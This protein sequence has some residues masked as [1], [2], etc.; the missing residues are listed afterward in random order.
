MAC[1]SY[2][3]ETTL[4][5]DD[6]G[7]GRSV[8]IYWDFENLHAG[9]V[10]GKYGEGTYAK[11]DNRFKPQEP[12]VDVQALVELG[13]SF[14]PVAINRA[15]CNWQF[16]GRYRDAL[17]QSAVELIQLFPP[18]ASAKNG[19]DIK[20][21]LDATEDISRFDHI[22]TVIIIGGDSDFMPVAQK[23]KAAGRTLIGIGNRK[24]TNKH[25]AKSCHEFRYYDS[26]VEPISTEDAKPVIAEDAPPPPQNLAA[27]ILRRAIRLLAESKGDAWVHKA[28]VWPMIKRLDPTFD[29]KDHGYTSFGEMLKALD[30]VVEVKKGD[31]DH[32][33]RLR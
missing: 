15:Y 13:S 14:G 7:N 5:Y 8:A 1:D 23:I 16:F 12:L 11:Q 3:G 25:W 33:L 28:N 18:G 17:L 31:K 24:N 4:D 10:E 32:L 2:T 19:A 9:L 20:L 6:S 29:P 21:C 26:L 30:A 27:E 22:G